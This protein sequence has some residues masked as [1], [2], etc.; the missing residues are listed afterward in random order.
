MTERLV[1]E[2]YDGRYR[3][4]DMQGKLLATTARRPEA[5]DF[6]RGRGARVR[7][8]WERT[9]IGGQ[10]VPRDFS[11]THGGHIAGRMYIIVGGFDRDCWA[12]FVNGEDPDSGRRGGSTGSGTKDEAIEQLEL[13]YTRFIADSDKYRPG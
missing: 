2:P 8:K 10:T 6:V 12:W 9:V 4:L 7:L 3:V 13:A 1:V 5:F 11:A